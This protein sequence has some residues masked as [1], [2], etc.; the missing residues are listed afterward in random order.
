MTSSTPENTQENV[1]EGD[2]LVVGGIR[3]EPGAHIGPYV[4]ERI[5]G[6]GGMATVLLAR[7]PTGLAVALKVLKASRIASGQTRFRREFR[8]LSRVNH[9][10][11]IRVESFGDIYGHP[12]IAM[13]YVD[14]TDLHQTIRSFKNLS[15]EERWK[16][17]EQIL[18]D[19]VRALAQVHRKGLVHRDL[20]P[21]N[22]LIDRQGRSKLTDFGIVKDLDPSADP[23]VSNTLVGTWAYASPEQIAGDPIDHRSDLYSLGVILFAMLTGRRP[24][25]AKDMAGYLELHRSRPAPRP[26][27]VNSGVPEHLDEICIRLLQK[28]P[29]NRFQSAQEVL[30]RLERAGSVTE[31]P[32]AVAWEPPFV[33]R[34]VEIDVLKD[35][36][37]GLTRGE[38]A[39]VWILGPLGSGRTR[40]LDVAVGQ[41]AAMGFPVHQLRSREAGGAVGA[42][43]HL[44]EEVA[45]DLD[46]RAT[47]ELQ[48]L[49]L[50]FVEDE[51]RK[52]GD[53]RYRLY[54]A[55]RKAIELALVQG[56]RVIA[57]DDLHLAE[58]T[59][60]DLF[61]FLLR[62][63][64]ARG[65]PLLVI[66]T[67]RTDPPA[68]LLEQ[69][70]DPAILG[71]EPTSLE[72]GPLAGPEILALVTNMLG[73]AAGTRALAARL[74]RETEGNPL[75]LIQFLAS[76]QEREIIVRGPGGYALAIDTEE[77]RSGHL[78]IPAEIRHLLGKRLEAASPED[79]QVLEVVATNGR[80]L[81]LDVLLDVLATPRSV[82][83]A[84]PVLDEDQLL[85]AIDRLVDAGLLLEHRAG[86]SIFLDFCH[87]KYA[88]ILYRD[89]P[90]ERRARLHL[91]LAQVHESRSGGSA[92]AAEVIGE[93]YRRATEAGKAYQHLAIAARR[94]HER[95]A[96]PEAW[97]L[98]EKALGL[99]ETARL[100][101]PGAAFSQARRILLAVRGDILFG[102]GEWDQ[103]RR[104]QEEVLEIAESLELPLEAARARL[105]LGTTERH[106]ENP[107][108]AVSLMEHA[109]REAR[110]TGDRGLAT[111]ALQ[112]LAALAWDR[113][114]LESCGAFAAEG[115]VLATGPDLA[116]PRARLLLAQT[117]L[118][119]S[120]GHMAS[121]TIGLA[122]AEGI[123]M[124]LGLKRSRCLALTNLAEF[125]TWQGN[126]ARAWTCAIDAHVL[127]L[128]VLYRLGEGIALRVSGEVAMELG[129]MTQARERLES[130]LDIL[131]PL[132]T[133]SELVAA[134]ASLGRLELELGRDAAAE[135]HLKVARGLAGQR[136]PE[137][138][139]PLVQAR[140]ALLF[141]K[142]GEAF[143]AES[144]LEQVLKEREGI[145]LPR[146]IQSLGVAA[147]VLA[148]L[149]RTDE[150]V[151][152]ARRA[153][154][155]ALSRGLKLWA[156]DALV[157]LA[158]HVPDESER[159]HHAEQARDLA[160]CTLA[161][162]PEDMATGLRER[163]STV[164]GGPV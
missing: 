33:G 50:L 8:A 36:I 2:D 120:Q 13:E 160:R 157:L 130:A 95:S 93:H 24:F 127:S 84:G 46:P 11:V 145:P 164:L 139:L 126:L 17:C 3:L 14:G 104:I 58:S 154:E 146:F 34:T 141:H 71:F 60:I 94:L 108:L 19:L 20:K 142:S 62:T 81:D 99:E 18:V 125:H 117:A 107:G 54:D 52:R 122:E 103:A 88:D 148:V 91:R 27:E 89:L 150:A 56:P 156:F 57:A 152:V 26:R 67:V 61:A 29:R 49:L 159:A 77:V 116:G 114:D 119:A 131:G 63:V 42:L 106:L 53:L 73:D 113:G 1:E 72:L 101:L 31:A 4:Y 30:A 124:E 5:I 32:V 76:L 69:I 144:M 100:Q 96:T 47:A 155:L 140:L 12:Y 98:S 128:E 66:G 97:D 118:Q 44:V 143:Q 10:N 136:D 115:L 35:R 75:F 40:L 25:V 153:S 65:A 129:R 15:D 68:P 133:T 21:S 6:R 121:A 41:A 16:R 149:L 138:Y 45:R 151:R 110:A 23:N 137:G 64:A 82:E 105:A 38:G 83:E 22:V 135:R 111:Q 79:R 162:L 70:Q 80:E 87:G 51:G 158:R 92:A 161:A 39:A 59:V 9:P 55:I 43:T 28:A 123:F 78:E 86:S 37:A 74:E 48:N 7:D 163:M 147:Q 90:A 132:K 134:R 112:G 85:D 102:R 109:L